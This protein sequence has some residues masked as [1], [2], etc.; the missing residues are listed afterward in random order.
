AAPASAV[1]NGDEVIQTFRD[2]GTMLKT[3]TDSFGGGR[4]EN[5]PWHDMET[6]KGVPILT[7]EFSDGKATSE[8]R[9][10]AARKESVPASSFEVPAG[11]TEKK[12]NFGRLGGAPAD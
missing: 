7:R 10:S 8:T 11:Y 5:Q 9:L 12:M 4:D 1:P 6:I 2:I 3:L